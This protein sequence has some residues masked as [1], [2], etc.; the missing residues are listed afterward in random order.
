MFSNLLELR[1]FHLIA[2]LILT[3]GS[4]IVFLFF[5]YLFVGMATS[6]FY[7]TQRTNERTDDFRLVLTTIAAPR[8]RDALMETI[9]HHLDHF[10]EYEFFV[11]I[12]EGAELGPELRKKG[13]IEVITVPDDYEC[14]AEAKGRA[15]N[16]FI[17]AV[18]AN[19]PEYWYGFIDDDNRIMDDEFLFEIPYY[20][21]RGYGA[22][23]PVLVPRLGRSRLTFIE[24]HMRLLEDLTI[25]RF[26]AGVLEKPYLG[27]HGELLTIKGDVMVDITF[28][29]KT[30]VEDFAFAMELCRR[31][32]KTWQSTT[33]VSILSP[34]N[35]GEWLKQRRRWYIGIVKYLPRSPLPTKLIVGLRQMLIALS[36]TAVWFFAPLWIFFDLFSVP[37]VIYLGV[38]L[39][40]FLH[41]GTCLY[42]A[43]RIAGV[44]S[45]FLGLLTPFYALM[46]QVV[47]I[48][49]A[50]TAND[51][52]TGFVVINK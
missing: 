13:G 39:G 32:I 33:R 5:L 15:I 27:L 47:P 2:E 10:S 52:N 4:L 17:E 34:H 16:Y 1:I 46:E 8:V 3:A 7:S 48:Y 35:I 24:D 51:E 40:S 38:L 14:K 41:L 19:G 29:R 12:D 20:D 25:F 9:D 44:K 36:F 22:M 43:Y 42:G 11:V 6:P 23:N 26:F 49:S 50:L 21:E 18:V 30:I 45:V 28:N 31:D 37:V